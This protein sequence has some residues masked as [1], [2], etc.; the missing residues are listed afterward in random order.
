M[1]V[2]DALVEAVVVPNMVL[3]VMMCPFCVLIYVVG[4]LKLPTKKRK[5]TGSFL[6]FFCFVF[7][8]EKTA[9]FFFTSVLF[10]FSSSFLITQK[11]DMRTVGV[12]LLLPSK[13]SRTNTYTTARRRKSPHPKR[14]VNARRTVLK[15]AREE[16]EPNLVLCL[17]IPDEEDGLEANQNQIQKEDEEEEGVEEGEEEITV[18]EGAKRKIGH[19]CDVCGKMFDRPSK[20]AIHIRTHTK[21][22]PYECDV[23][24]KRFTT[25]SSLQVHMRIHT[26]EKPYECDVCE[27]RFRQS[28]HLQ[29]HKRIHTG[30]KPYECDLCE[31][32]FRRLDTLKRHKRLCH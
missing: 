18:R 5:P 21:E 32:R 7:F 31:K 13:V 10:F 15:V 20:L 2:L 29:T 16:E 30:E 4:A 1:L 11:E 19:E 3:Y 27:M 12:N 25:S 26:N 6:R 22:K 28:H 23:C 24:E 8:F 17:R 14:A 9:I